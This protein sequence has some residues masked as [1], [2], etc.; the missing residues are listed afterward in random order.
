MFF[1]MKSNL[2][3]N[4]IPAPAGSLVY[5]G[6]IDEALAEKFAGASSIQKLD[7]SEAR[8]AI[9]AGDAQ[10]VPLVNEAA[11]EIPV[12]MELDILDQALVD[13]LDGN[14]KTV[15]ER[16][17]DLDYVE[18][19]EELRELEVNGLGRK[20]VFN[21]IDDRIA[22]LD[23]DPTPADAPAHVIEDTEVTE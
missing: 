16:I 3:I 23:V 11:Q 5:E 22:K 12:E 17:A 10:R 14:V 19:L 2:V 4:G 9:A 18:D 13:I 20:G 7:D 21:A 15:S 8:D 6:D 1:R